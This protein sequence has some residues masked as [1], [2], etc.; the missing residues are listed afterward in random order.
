MSLITDSSVR[1]VL[2]CVVRR[3]NPECMC[4][5]SHKVLA[6]EGGSAMARVNSMNGNSTA[7]SGLLEHAE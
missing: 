1:S 5:L 4:F 6:T 2:A 7:N 3:Y